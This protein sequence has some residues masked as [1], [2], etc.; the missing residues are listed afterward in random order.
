MSRFRTLA[1]LLTD[2]VPGPWGYAYGS[3]WALVPQ[4]HQSPDKGATVNHAIMTRTTSAPILPT[5]KDA[6]MELASLSP[7]MLAAIVQAV[8]GIQDF[9]A[10]CAAAEHTDTGAAWDVMHD[11]IRILTQSIGATPE[12]V[13]RLP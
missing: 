1:Q 8:K 3:V 2:S 4:S 7:A 10:E 11:T 13:R 6:S 5:A 12:E 9:D